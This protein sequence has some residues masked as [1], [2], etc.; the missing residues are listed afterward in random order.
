LR[1][2]KSNTYGDA[3]SKRDTYPDGNADWNAARDA[4][5]D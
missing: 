2:G 5:A 3:A 1:S 4:D